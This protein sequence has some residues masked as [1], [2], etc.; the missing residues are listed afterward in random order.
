MRKERIFGARIFG[1]K[2]KL[3]MKLMKIIQLRWVVLCMWV[4]MKIMG[5]FFGENFIKFKFI[6]NYM[7]K[8]CTAHGK[9]RLSA[10]NTISAP[11]IRRLNVC[12][13]EK[14]RKTTICVQLIIW[15]FFLLLL[16][17]P[18]FQNSINDVSSE[19]AKKKNIFAFFCSLYYI[20]QIHI[21]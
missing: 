16:F 4:Q 8:M 18:L 13:S 10:M 14:N 20:P 7:V 17:F 5:T 9:T 6:P 19:R 2:K 11:F 1:K 3:K 21:Y 15:S 12:V